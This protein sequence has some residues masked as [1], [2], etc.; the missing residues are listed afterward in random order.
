MEKLFYVQIPHMILQITSY[1]TDKLTTNTSLY[2][3]CVFLSLLLHDLQ[4]LI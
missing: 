1:L 2:S 4:T 3:A